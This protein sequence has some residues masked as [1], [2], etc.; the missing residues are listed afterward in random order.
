MKKENIDILKNRFPSLFFFSKHC[1]TTIDASDESFE[2]IFNFCKEIS[3]ISETVKITL[4]KESD[5]GL[6]FFI[7]EY[8]DELLS[9]IDYHEKI[10]LKQCVNNIIK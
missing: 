7:N 6:S 10:N 8:R 5:Y 4:I 2:K 3:A 9:I 1:S